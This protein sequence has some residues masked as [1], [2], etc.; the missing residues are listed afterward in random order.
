MTSPHPTVPSA[1]RKWLQVWPAIEDFRFVTDELQAL[2]SP[3]RLLSVAV[4][5][6]TS[7]G[8]AE[9][10]KRFARPG[11]ATVV[12]SRE[13]VDERWLGIHTHFSL[14]RDVPQSTYGMRP[15]IQ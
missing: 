14:G 10:G 12:L 6:W 8:V 4:V 9:N 2:I 3:D 11:R 7:I 15:P 13:S 1:R 5:G